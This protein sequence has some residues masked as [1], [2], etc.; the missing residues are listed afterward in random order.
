MHFENQATLA[1]SKAAVWSFLMDIPKAA[2]CVPGA[3][4]VVQLDSDTSYTGV[5][6]VRVGPISLSLSGTVTV[7]ERDEADGRATMSAQAS[8]RRIGGAVNAKVTMTIS[9]PSPGETHLSVVTDANVLGR[10]GEFGQP[11][12][13]KKSEQIMQQF[14]ANIQKQLSS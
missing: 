12:I 7:E 2:T 9:E 13:R 14:V 5:M 10:L 6:K 4:N 11:V 1:A 3:E 8:D